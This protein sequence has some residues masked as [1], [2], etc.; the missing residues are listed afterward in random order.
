MHVSFAK[1]VLT[2]LVLGLFATP[3][4]AAA[5]TP[6]GTADQTR[7]ASPVGSTNKAS[8]TATQ[9]AIET[10]PG[11]GVENQALSRLIDR[12]HTIA[13]LEAGI[14]DLPN[15][16]ISPGQRGG[17]TPF[18]TIG[19]GDATLSA[20]IHVLYRWNRQF[21]VGFGGI[22]APAPTGDSEYGGL[23]ALPRTHARSYLFLGAEGRYIPIH[24]HRFEA[25]VGANLGA[26]V[27]ADRFTTNAGDDVPAILG[28][29]EVTIRTEGFA[30]GLE[31]G[32]HYFLTENFSAGASLRAQRWLLPQTQRCSPIGDCATLA[33]TVEAFELGLTLS[34]RVPL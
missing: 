28:A 12:P 31:T 1:P 17:N 10:K 34:Y 7:S 26:V 22:F 9:L 24:Y 19:R 3:R 15:A 29:K 16:P 6:P 14:I 4:R 8:A 21:A 18:G 30:F 5:E 25:W 33:G 27:V 23:R 11:E 2:M 32:A 13:E 20:G